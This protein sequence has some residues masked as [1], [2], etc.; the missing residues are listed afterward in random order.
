MTTTV[1]AKIIPRQGT[2][3]QWTAANPVLLFGERGMETDTGL[4]KIGD[5]TTAWNALGYT[6]S[7]AS[8]T[9]HINSTDNPHGTTAAQVGALAPGDDAA[10]LGSGTAADGYVLTADGAGGTAWEAATGG[11]AGVSDHGALTGLNDDD[12]TQYHTDARGDARYSLL[13]HAHSGTYDPAGTAS[14]AVSTHEST[15]DHAAF[16]TAEIDPVFSA[17]DKS[18]GISITESQISD[19]GDY[20]PADATIL[21][22]ADIGVTVQGY[23]ADTSK[24]DTAETFTGKKTLSGGY[25]ETAELLTQSSGTLTIVLGK[26]YKVVPSEAIT[27]ITVTA[28]TAP[29]ASGSIID[30]VMG[31]A[32]YA[33]SYPSTWLWPGGTVTD[34]D[35]TASAQTTLILRSDYDG[36]IHAEAS[37]R[38]TA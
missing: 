36:N 11:G 2:A 16:L 24:T 12:H 18:T 22:D 34:I 15:Y 3:A 6:A 21:K 35:D 7:E 1:V 29:I 4:G 10:D 27:A 37:V 17:W 38:S 23:D 13:G 32:G 28:P 30:F 20:E 14:S 25:N 26:N 31:A 8:A 33:V 9:A 19:L 5:G